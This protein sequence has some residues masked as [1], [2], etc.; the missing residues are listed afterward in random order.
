MEWRE[1]RELPGFQ[2]RR[3]H[4]E[5]LLLWFPGWGQKVTPLYDLPAH[6]PP[7]SAS[8]EA[9]D[10]VLIPQK[11]SLGHPE[12]CHRS[13]TG[14]GRGAN[15][16]TLTERWPPRRLAGS[17]RAGNAKL[18]R[19][20]RKAGASLKVALGSDWSCWPLPPAHGW[21]SRGPSFFPLRAQ[22]FGG[23]R[24]AHSSRALGRKLRPNGAEAAAGGKD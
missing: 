23:P 10:Q 4:L 2:T 18:P 1:R 13:H 24:N 12:E 8:E 17:Q 14:K 9:L 20:R 22:N 3:S 5:P 16:G 19:W 6:Q 21:P 7:P 15:P 11:A